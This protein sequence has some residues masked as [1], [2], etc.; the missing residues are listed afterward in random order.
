MEPVRVL[1]ERNIEPDIFYANSNIAPDAE[2]DKRFSTLSKWAEDEK[3]DVFEGKRDHDAW[4]RDVEAPWMA[5]NRDETARQERCRACYRL[6]FEEAASWAATNGYAELGTT[7]S[8]S[9]YQYTGIIREELER[10]CAAYGI[11]PAFEDWRPNYDEATRRSREAGMYRQNYCGCAIS[12][13]E[14]ASEREERR[15]ARI[16]ERERW[17]AEHAEELAAKDAA[18][19]AR[20]EERRAYDEK[21]ARQKAI[22]KSLRVKTCEGCDEDI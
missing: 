2:Y 9:P 21:R 3:I 14:A 19:K 11:K 1:R 16:A 13:A 18:I 5:S 10:A 20:R 22:L 4:K 15:K 12:A 6:R 17:K 7:L 8:V